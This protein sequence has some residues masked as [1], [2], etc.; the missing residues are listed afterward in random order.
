[1]IWYD[2]AVIKLNHLFESMDHIGLTQKLDASLRLWIN[3][4]TVNV[5]VGG[6]ATGGGANMTYSIILG[7]RQQACQSLAVYYTSLVQT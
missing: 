7:R 4:G 1:M 3:C 6:N 5:T 2:F